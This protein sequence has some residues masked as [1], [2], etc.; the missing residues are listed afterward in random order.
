[1]RT[2]SSP[3][4]RPSFTTTLTGCVKNRNSTPSRRMNSISCLYAL[5]SCSDRRYTIVT[6]S[7]PS[8]FA[9][10]AQSIAVFPA[11]TTITRL[12]TCSRDT[13]SL[14][15]SMYASPSTMYSSPG[16]C[17]SGVAPNPTLKKTASNWLR[18]SAIFS[19]RHISTP[20]RN[21]TPSRRIISI[22][23]SATS[24]GSRSPIMP[25]VDSPPASSR[26]SKT[27]TAYPR[28]ASSP[29]HD[30]PAAPAPTTAIFLPVRA[31]LPNTS[32]PAPYT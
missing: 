23:A 27:V 7:A 28:L 17:N 3:I 15:C 10:V 26:F 29:A 12:P 6:C 4:T 16:I 25:Y 14:L 18:I 1:M 24:T 11:P 13:S 5:T 31:T 30:N 9:I 22:S 21:S 2:H 8:R 32:M 19:S 20:V